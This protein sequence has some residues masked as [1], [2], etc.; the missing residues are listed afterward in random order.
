MSFGEP[1]DAGNLGD[2][3]DSPGRLVNL[4][5]GVGVKTSNGVS[6]AS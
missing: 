4:R 5:H 1:V 6:A 3:G 2:S